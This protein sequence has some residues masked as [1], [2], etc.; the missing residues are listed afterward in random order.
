MGSIERP[1]SGRAAERRVGEP[2][3]RWRAELAGLDEY[4]LP[5]LGWVLGR[6]RHARFRIGPSDRRHALSADRRL[7]EADRCEH[8]IQ[9]R[10]G[11]RLIGHVRSINANTA[12]RA[13]ISIRRRSSGSSN[14]SPGSANAS[15]SSRGERASFPRAAA[16]P[17]T[18]AWRERRTVRSLRWPVPSSST[19]ASEIRKARKVRC[20]SS[21]PEIRVEKRVY[22]QITRASRE[23]T[24][25]LES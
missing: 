11:R 3:C 7:V 17:E 22:R 8:A 25:G 6:E 12:L 23:W 9:R 10:H 19:S 15:T 1:T 14:D 2:R 16:I 20:N 18:R 21:S 24:S 5:T 4:R 13:R